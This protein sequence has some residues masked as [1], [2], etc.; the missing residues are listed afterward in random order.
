MIANI[1]LYFDLLLIVLYFGFFMTGY[2]TGGNVQLIKLLK[3]TLPFIVIYYYGGYISKTV[4]MNDTFENF[5]S[6]FFQAFT[7]F[8]YYN[9]I[10]VALSIVISY[11]VIYF[12]TGIIINMIA[13]RILKDRVTFALG[14]YNQIIGGFLSV[15]RGYIVL[16][17]VIV[18]FYMLNITNESNYISGFMINNPPKFTRIGTVISASKPGMDVANSVTNFL[19]VT[20]LSPDKILEY[21]NTIVGYR[22]KITEYEDTITTI[23]ND[24][25]LTPEQIGVNANP[26][27]Q[28]ILLAFIDN[29]D[30]FIDNADENTKEELLQLKSYTNSYRG[31]ILWAYDNEGVFDDNNQAINSFLDNYDEIQSNTNDE[32][33]SAKLET[34]KMNIDTYNVFKTWLGDNGYENIL[35]RNAYQAI[36]EQFDQDY[37]M[38][39]SQLEEYDQMSLKLQQ[40]KKL[41]DKYQDKKE[42]IEKMPA[43]LDFIFKLVII[44]IQ[45]VDVLNK[46]EESPLIATFITDSVKFLSN[47]NPE[48][49]DYVV[50]VTIPL[51]LTYDDDFNL[52]PV[53]ETRMDSLLTIIDRSIKNLVITEEFLNNYV[54]TLMTSEV[55]VEN[56]NGGLVTE[57][58]IDT[59]I[60]EGAITEE[61]LKS[62]SNCE[63]LTSENKALLDTYLSELSNTGGNN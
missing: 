52:T 16:C 10:I 8:S 43:D 45:D 49:N 62:F 14:K 59:L 41:S 33:M 40:M 5:I 35:D 39:Y 53:D 18:P 42:L 51:Y 19:D 30:I 7:E 3:L 63:H 34:I 29:P 13:K 50:Q 26:T 22:N 32:V 31:L 61:A 2:I 36:I 56:D 47:T 60:D 1:P 17:I 20:D 6:S 46:M 12:I 55:M 4:F 23:Y 44:S 37:D 38:L 15:V 27:N 24:M 57:L 28:D 9:T 48:I 25:G 54:N 21:Y 11:I 58:Y